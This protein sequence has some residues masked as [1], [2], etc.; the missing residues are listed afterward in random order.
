MRQPVFRTTL[1]APFAPHAL[2]ARIRPQTQ[3]NVGRWL[4]RTVGKRAK[5]LSINAHR[6]WCI[7]R[8]DDDR[9]LYA[10]DE[11][12]ATTHHTETPRDAAILVSGNA[13]RDSHV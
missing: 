6:V 11:A 13:N 2:H 12:R 7:C 10:V 9:N 8:Y 1:Q 3:V 4:E 5:I